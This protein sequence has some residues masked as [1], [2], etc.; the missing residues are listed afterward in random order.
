MKDSPNEETQKLKDT[1]KKA[2]SCYNDSQK[3]FSDSEPED[4]FWKSLPDNEWDIPEKE[5]IGYQEVSKI[6]IEFRFIIKLQTPIIISQI[7]Y[8]V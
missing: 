3:Y 7:Y 6:R 4:N 8:R 2:R 5:K 1:G